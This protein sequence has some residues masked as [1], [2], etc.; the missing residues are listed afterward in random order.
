MLLKQ[1]RDA[2]AHD[3]K[4]GYCRL[5]T[6]VPTGGTIPIRRHYGSVPEND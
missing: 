3:Q 1:L 2:K 5:L 6:I 4:W